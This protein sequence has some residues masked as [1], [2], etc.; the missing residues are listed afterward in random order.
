MVS[1]GVP[2]LG[3]PKKEK[4]IG[5]KITDIDYSIVETDDRS[6]RILAQSHPRLQN[7]N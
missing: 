6:L 4:K 7:L 3:S 5:K 2:Q 1:A